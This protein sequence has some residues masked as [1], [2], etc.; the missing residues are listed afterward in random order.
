M[1]ARNA[2]LVALALVLL[3][4]GCAALKNDMQLAETAY[5]EARYDEALIWLDDLEKDTPDMDV[6][7]QARFYYLRGMTAYRLGHRNDALHYLAVAREVAGEE[8]VTTLRPEW[9][10]AMDRTLTELTPHDRSFRAREGS[11]GDE[12]GESTEPDPSPES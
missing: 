1:K 5:D 3:A 4:L 8:S 7:M 10:Q 2:P 11:G 6:E 12:A 9:R